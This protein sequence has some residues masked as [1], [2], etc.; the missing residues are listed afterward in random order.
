MTPKRPPHPHVAKA[1][2]YIR[3]VLAAKIPACEW[4]KRACRRHREDM[5]RSRQ[6][7]YPFKFDGARAEKACQF[8]E[9]M[10]HVKGHWAANGETIRL[11][12]FQ[13]FER[14]M[15]FG[16]VEKQTGLRRFRTAYICRPRKN[17]KSTD[18]AITGLYML[19]ADGEHGGEVYSGAATEKQ[20][21]E[22]FRPAKQM[23]ERT[24]TFRDAFGVEVHAK[25]LTVLETG[26]RFEPMIGKPGDGASPSL[27]I[28]DEYHEHP[29]SSQ[30]DTMV[31]GMG[32]RLHPLTL[33]ITTAG[34][35]VEGPCY[36]LQERA[37]KVLNGSLPD[38]R[39]FAIIYTIDQD[40]DWTTEAALRKAN[41]NYD[42]SVSGEYLKDRLRVALNEPR[43]QNVFKTK[44]LNIWCQSR[45]P[46]MNMEWWHRQADAS[47]S[48][49]AFVGERCWLAFDL[50]NRVDLVSTALIFRR[51]EDGQAHFYY[52]GR[53][54]APE[55]A[56]QEP[57]K[58]H[59][60]GW[61]ADGHLIA[62]EGND[63]DLQRI[64]EDVA[65]DRAR[66]DIEESAIDPWNSIG[67]RDRL[68]EIDVAVLEVPQTVSHF[69]EP[70]KAVEALVKDG[71]FHH[72]GNP[73]MT[74]Q[75]GNVTVKPDAKDNIFPRKER[76]EKK[77]D[78]PVAMIM[79]MKLAMGAPVDVGLGLE[80]V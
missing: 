37:Q 7:A 13:C 61:V 57:D 52:F 55:A 62:T 34:E 15:L 45:S 20:A 19:G 41:P 1:Q 27:A 78:G 21:W 43:E 44:H 67:L 40:D 69:S 29:D 58:R 51:E 77:I 70:M 80:L 4:V 75:M 30:Y 49:M 17:A 3:E 11:E 53:H 68:S 2:R 24:P 63:C 23:A 36:A 8:A 48:P 54:Y 9:L 39:V 64:A 12:P 73:C 28:I 16:W 60:Q 42:V 5:K 18:A 35:D 6:K 46:W 33:V 65:E 26:S 22:V 76:R 72:D 38:E 47:L 32:A 59:Y 79:A 66:F 31:S 74:W 25:S 14:A 56:V 10:P 71:R 50:A